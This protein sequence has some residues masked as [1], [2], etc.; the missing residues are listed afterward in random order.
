MAVNPR[1]VGKSVGPRANL[2]YHDY[3]ADVGAVIDRIAGG[4]AHVLG[5]AWGKPIA[6][7]L[8]A[9]SPGRV[10]SITLIAAGGKFPSDPSVAALTKQIAQPGMSAHGIVVEH[11]VRL[12][13]ETVRFLR[14]QPVQRSR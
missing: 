9:D 8:A 11:P 12:A 1:G 10:A 13:D 5:W 7:C 14:A 4:R 2:T 3:A 6:R